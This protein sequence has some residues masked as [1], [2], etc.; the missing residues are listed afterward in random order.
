MRYFT[1]DEANRALPRVRPLVERLVEARRESLRLEERL[2]AVRRRVLG[3]GGGLDPAR[4]E[5]LQTEATAAAKAVLELAE[6][7]DDLGVQVKDP[8]TGLVDFPARHPDGTDVLLCW[9]LGEDAV[10]FW[11]TLDGGFRGRRPLPF[12][13][14]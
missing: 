14:T 6:R 2:G 3:N 11:H 5:E 7:L 13:R 8:D 1:P 10:A 4:I 9:R 12:G